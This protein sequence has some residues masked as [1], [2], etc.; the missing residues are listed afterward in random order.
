ATPGA[1]SRPDGV[2]AANASAG[3]AGSTRHG[4]LHAAAFGVQAPV[5]LVPG[6]FAS[7]A[8]APVVDRHREIP[9]FPG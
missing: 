1:P 8:P 7:G 9:E 4:D 6:A 2:P 3:D 5:L